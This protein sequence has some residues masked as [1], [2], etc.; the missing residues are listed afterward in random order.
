MIMVDVKIQ[1]EVKC[2][3]A[4]Y[5]RNM[6]HDLNKLRTYIIHTYLIYDSQLLILKHL[7]FQYHHNTE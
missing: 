7:Q 4:M 6:V 1:N 5:I 3:Y 2:K